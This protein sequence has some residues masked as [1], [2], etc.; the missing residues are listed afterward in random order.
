MPRTYTV[1]EGTI[2][3]PVVGT[4]THDGLDVAGGPGRGEII[5][6]AGSYWRVVDDAEGEETLVVRAVD[7]VEGLDDVG[8]AARHADQA[9]DEEQDEAD[10]VAG[11]SGPHVEPRPGDRY[12]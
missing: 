5:D 10:N 9:R 8:M 4:Y 6:V 12:T 7:D 3:G 2:A 11:P 1:H